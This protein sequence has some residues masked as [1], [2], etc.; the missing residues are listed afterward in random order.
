MNRKNKGKREKDPMDGLLAIMRG[1]ILVVTMTALLASPA[2][3]AENEV[4]DAINNLTELL[5]GVIRAVGMILAGW[6][7][8]QIGMSINA[9]DS[10]ARANGILALVGGLFIFFTKNILDVIIG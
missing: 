5:F 6:G 3:A 9:H 8:V 4:L 10:S 2:L 1:S 7:M